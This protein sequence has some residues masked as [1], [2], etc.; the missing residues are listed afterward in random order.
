MILAELQKDR[1]AGISAELVT[2]GLK[3]AGQLGEELSALLIGENTGNRAQE[4]IC[5]GVHKVY[6]VDNPVFSCYR[7]EPY[8]ELIAR[9]CQEIQPNVF[10]M[11]HTEVGQDLGPRLAFRLNTGFVPNCVELGVAPESGLLQMT[12]PV[13]GGK[14][15]GLY[16]VNNGGL[17]IATVAPK[18]FEAALREDSRQGKITLLPWEN[19]AT[20][21][22][23]QVVERVETESAGV[24][25]EDATVIVSGG[26]GVGSAEDF[27]GLK[28]LADTLGGSIGASRVAVDNNWVPNILQVGLTGKVVKPNVYIAIGI[29]GSLQHMAGCSTAKTIIAINR[30]P[31]AQIFKM[32][33]FGVVADWREI[34]PPL[35]EKCKALSE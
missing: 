8:L 3:I 21:F 5:L 11:G 31:E 19:E 35:I 18:V 2:A 22:K 32:A 24:R 16:M 4:L 7:F 14:A 12:R 10:L 9:I 28:E 34:L 26:R 15:H 25:L 6:V 23:I 1:L 13:Y 17:Q 30:D 27:A 20:S 33:H 29:S